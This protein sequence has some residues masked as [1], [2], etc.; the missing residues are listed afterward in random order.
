MTDDL[1]GRVS[2][3]SHGGCGFDP[4][5]EEA[6]RFQSIKKSYMRNHVQVAEYSFEI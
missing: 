4:Y 6:F 3:Y 1:D 2:A 5:L